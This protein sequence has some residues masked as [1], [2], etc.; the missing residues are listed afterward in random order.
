MKCID[1]FTCK[2]NA[3]TIKKDVIAP[4]EI[5]DFY[6]CSDS[7]GRLEIQFTVPGD[8]STEGRAYNYSLIITS[9]N[10]II[11]YDFEV[12]IPSEANTL[13]YWRIDDLPFNEIVTVKLDAYDEVGNESGSVQETLTIADVDTIAPAAITDLESTPQLTTIEL[14]WTSPDDD[15]YKGNAVSYEIKKAEQYITEEI[16]QD[17]EILNNVPIPGE[18]NTL[19]TFVVDDS[20]VQDIIYY[21]AIKTTDDSGNI[22]ELSNC[23]Y[24]EIIGDTIQPATITDLEVTSTG[25]YT[26]HIRWTAPGDDGLEGSAEYYVI[27][28]AQDVITE[29]N[30]SSIE[31]YANTIIP[32]SAGGTE[33]FLFDGLEGNTEYYISIKAVDEIGNIS[34]LSNVVQAVTQELPDETPPNP[35]SDLAAEESE[36]E[37]TLSWTAPGDDG[38]VGTA[39][40]YV[41]KYSEE[42]ITSDNWSAALTLP[43]A[44]I[45]EE[46]GSVQEYVVNE[47]NS[48]I[49]YYFAIRSYDDVLNISDLSNVVSAS[50]LQDTTPLADITDLQ[51][52]SAETEIVL[53]W[54]APGDDGDVG[55][56]TLYD[57]RYSLVVIS[58]ANWQDATMID[59]V[60]DPLPAGTVQSYVFN[61]GSVGTD[62]FFAIKSID[63]NE[64]VSGISNVVTGQ[65]LGDINPP[66][67]VQDLSANAT[68]ETITLRWTAPGDDGNIGT[69]QSYDIR[70]ST[71]QLDDTNWDDAIQCDDEP[72]P[73]LSG[74]EQQYVLNNL[75]PGEIYYFGLKTADENGNISLLSNVV[76]S[77]LLQDTTPPAAIDDLL[78][79]NVSSY[80]I[81]IRWTAVGDDGNE[82]TADSYVIKI[83]NE[84]INDSN[85]ESIPEY[86]Q[87]I[88]PQQSGME[89]T[90]L[91]SQIQPET[92]YYIGMK[93]FDEAQ[94]I[95]GLSN[96]VNAT[97]TATLDTIPPAQITDLSANST[98]IDI[99][100]SWTA[101]GDDGDEG[102]AALYEMKRN[103]ETITPENWDASELLSNLPLPAEPGTIQSYVV[104]DA[105]PGQTYYFALIT[106]DDASNASLIS[107]NA[108]GALL[109]DTIPPAQ[110]TDLSANSTEI[111]ITLSWTAPGDDG[112]TGTAESYDMRYALEEITETNWQNAIVIND[113]AAPSSAGTVQSYIFDDGPI[114]LDLFFAI[115][116]T[117]EN[118]NESGLS[119][120]VSGQILG[121]LTPPSAV[122]NLIITNVT[123]ESMTLSWTA[124]GDDGLSGT[125]SEYVIKIHT[126]E[127]TEQNWNS[128]PEYSQ[129]MTPQPSGSLEMLQVENLSPETEYFAAMKVLDE[130]QNISELSNVPNATTLEEPDIIP[131]DAITD[132]DSE[133]DETTITLSWTAP[134]DDGST[135]TAAF[136]EIR[137]SEE[138]ITEAN[139]SDATLLDNPPSPQPAGTVQSYDV[140]GLASGIVYYFAIKT[141]DDAM[142]VSDL[143]NVIFD[144]LEEDTTPPAQ[145][146]DLMVITGYAI[147][148]STIKIQWTAP[149][150]D[151][152]VGTADHYEIRYATFEIN[153]LNWGSA[154]IYPIPPTPQPAGTIQTC[155]VTGL[156]AATIYYFAIKAYDENNNAGSASNSPSGK[157][158]YQINAGPCNGCGNCVSHC[159]ENAIT[160]HGSYASIDPDLCVA[161]GVCVNWCPRNAI[162]LYVVS[163]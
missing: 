141:F 159:P 140:T 83:N 20:L 79:I 89:E 54:S 135:G 153:E 143:S 123:Y 48:G 64:N 65:I 121:D 91:I 30:W 137:R 8:D 115:K 142:N 70:Y 35:I 131:P 101:V 94:N 45:P 36:T 122:N 4:C 41:L 7:A 84:E 61:D 38:N 110:I 118:S 81:Q 96:I 88:T 80:S 162:H 10:D 73:L 75:I 146:T 86:D 93:V 132:L 69:A 144:M 15:G 111:D 76:S 120:V 112:N 32:Q 116:T 43:N 55:T 154:Q 104:T 28:I 74:T 11:E 113:V 128:I 117:D 50:L 82:G 125:A 63:D 71:E 68:E 16:W 3:I 27:K 78:I 33:N 114:A 147:N 107:N 100:L 157:I 37:I 156:S 31:E 42:F 87:N 56:A 19:Q 67:A 124:V 145:I 21:F 102:L 149:G 97:T 160:D 1:V 158:V 130:N 51:A 12:P 2:E 163:Y 44:P 139:W 152:N 66:S 119:N 99:T 150:D 155:S 18:P 133:A 17:A 34:G 90:L 127:I 5:K 92:E 57:L 105:E 161:C 24:N 46:S 136:Y 58:E 40:F 106:Y 138:L 6:T 98:E 52:E 13:E 134:G 60:P 39:S 25:I 103:T 72:A 53:Q 77:A 108:S 29:D 14:Q 148:N 85:W 151:G 23:T 9:N 126:E 109:Q 95:S 47:L 26:V 22:S 129:N 59:D 62:Y 49:E